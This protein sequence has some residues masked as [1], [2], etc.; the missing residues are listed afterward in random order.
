MTD[1]KKAPA[2]ETMNLCE[3]EEIYDLIL[4]LCDDADSFGLFERTSS[5]EIEKCK[6]IS[7]ILEALNDVPLSR[8]KHI[9]R[10]NKVNFDCADF[11]SAH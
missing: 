6:W 8:V 5:E 4:Q 11:I 2:T 3:Y 9:F 1:I 10:Q 7:V